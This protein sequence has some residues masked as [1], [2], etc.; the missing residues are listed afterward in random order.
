MRSVG[1]GSRGVDGEST[2]TVWSAVVAAA[3]TEVREGLTRLIQTQFG[4]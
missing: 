4:V 3:C 2:H 1:E